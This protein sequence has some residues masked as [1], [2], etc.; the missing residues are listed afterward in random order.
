[1]NIGIEFNIFTRINQR[2]IQN[3]ESII[4]KRNENREDL[5]EIPES[6]F[7]SNKQKQSKTKSKYKQEKLESID[8]ELKTGKIDPKHHNTVE[9]IHLSNVKRPRK[10]KLEDQ[11]NKPVTEPKYSEFQNALKNP[12]NI[13]AKK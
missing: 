12:N 13:S 11:N 3:K 5:P 6:I 8:P 4:N 7:V 10:I 2:I 1:M 9:K